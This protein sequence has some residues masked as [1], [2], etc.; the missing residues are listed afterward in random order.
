VFPDKEVVMANLSSLA[1]RSL[2]AGE[3]LES[4]R[5]LI[6]QAASPVVQECLRAACCEIAYLTCTEAALAE[7]DEDDAEGPLEDTLEAL[8]DA[9]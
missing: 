7:Q 4:L 1:P 9:G 2:D 3:V 6:A 8:K 5:R